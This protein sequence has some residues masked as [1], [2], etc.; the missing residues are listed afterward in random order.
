MHF[1]RV[2]GL[3]G[4]NPIMSSGRSV[5]NRWI[6]RIIDGVNTIFLLI[7]LITQPTA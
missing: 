2:I 7:I 1:Q 4:G 5:V 6:L 3:P